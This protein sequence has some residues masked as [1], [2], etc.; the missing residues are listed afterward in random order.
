MTLIALAH[1]AAEPHL[2]GDAA[3]AALALLFVAAVALA[4]RILRELR[5]VLARA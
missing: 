4:P 5:R 3:D 2:H 1:T